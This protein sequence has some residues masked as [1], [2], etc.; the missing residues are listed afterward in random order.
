MKEARVMF[1]LLYYDTADRSLNPALVRDVCVLSAI[2]NSS[3][4]SQHTKELCTTTL[5]AISTEL[6]NN[7]TSI[8]SANIPD[9]ELLGRD[10]SAYGF[11]TYAFKTTNTPE[12]SRAGVGMVLAR[13]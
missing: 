12:N 2:G 10:Y 6:G 8:N 5:A 4:A 13:H 3:T 9:S 11:D 1:D 7:P